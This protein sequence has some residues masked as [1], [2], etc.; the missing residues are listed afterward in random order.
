[1]SS[2]GPSTFGN[3]TSGLPFSS[4]VDR[5][6]SLRLRT[7]AAG[8]ALASVTP[9][10]GSAISRYRPWFSTFPSRRFS[11]SRRTYRGVACGKAPTALA[12][13][14]TRAVFRYRSS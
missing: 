1:M 3:L 14:N 9:L 13:F 4:L 2:P 12:I 5:Y 7:T 8:R 6:A 11:T 10:V